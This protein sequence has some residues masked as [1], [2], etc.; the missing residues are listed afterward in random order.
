MQVKPE[1]TALHDVLM[2]ALE[3]SQD[4][5]GKERHANEGA[6][7]VDQQIVQLCEWMGSHEG[8]VFQ[9]CKK[10]LES[11]RLPRDKA[12]RELLGS[13][14]YCAAA[15]IVLDREAARTDEALVESVRCQVIDLDRKQCTLDTHAI[16]AH[17]FQGQC[18]SRFGGER[19]EHP[20]DHVIM[21]TQ[22]QATLGTQH[23]GT[24]G[25]KW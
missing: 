21:G 25:A 15:I 6:S 22:A 4:G 7:F 3:Q 9:I 18:A 19:C 24:H 11:T 20:A 23:L 2:E 10:A 17:R 16:G 13:I 12:R 1:Y 8:A 14:V 5:K